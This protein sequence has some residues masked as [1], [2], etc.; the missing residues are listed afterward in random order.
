MTEL[1]CGNCHQKIQ[2]QL[3]NASQII[4]VD[5]KEALPEIIDT[6]FRDG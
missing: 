1:T 2:S 5:A 3:A 4:R 6:Y